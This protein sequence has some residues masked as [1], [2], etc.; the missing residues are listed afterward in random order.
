MVLGVILAKHQS[1]FKIELYQDKKDQR[2]NDK[3]IN[4]KRDKDG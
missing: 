1:T 4:H 2:N 3:S